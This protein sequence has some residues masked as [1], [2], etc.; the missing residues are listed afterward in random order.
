ML[1]ANENEIFRE[2][3]AWNQWKSIHSSTDDT[4]YALLLYI[5]RTNGLNIHKSTRHT[6]TQSQGEAHIL[7]AWIFRYK[8][9]NISFYFNLF[10]PQNGHV[11][12]LIQ[13][14]LPS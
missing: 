9:I 11:N 3:E 7:F 6:Y 13:I 2:I 14:L 8:I 10:D 12:F 1:C 4:Y 5:Y